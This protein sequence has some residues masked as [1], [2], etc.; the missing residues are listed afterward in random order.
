MPI[1]GLSKQGLSGRAL[2]WAA[3]TGF[4]QA[5]TAGAD[6]DE[7]RLPVAQMVV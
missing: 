7:E 5:A 4:I 6:T 1:F 3:W 2:A